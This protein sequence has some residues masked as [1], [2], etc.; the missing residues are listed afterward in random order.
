MLRAHRQAWAWQDEY[1]GLTLDDIRRLEQETQEALKK[2]MAALRQQEGG[3]HL[4][5]AHAADDLDI[6]P[7]TDSSESTLNTES[8]HTDTSDVTSDS[9]VTVA[10]LFKD[11]VAKNTAQHSNR[12]SN[13]NSCS[14]IEDNSAVDLPRAS[15]N[16]PVTKTRSRDVLKSVTV[17]RCTR[18]KSC[19]SFP[20]SCPWHCP[21]LCPV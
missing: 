13:Q 15:A 2:K 21:L 5:G 7:I 14:S 3:T 11:D 9:T 20:S 16:S 18:F 17:E 4:P 19:P 8:K 6:Q 12:N 1:H 10:T